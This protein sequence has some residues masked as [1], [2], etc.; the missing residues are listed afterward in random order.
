MDTEKQ[1]RVY[2]C[3]NIHCRANGSERLLR[4]LE[5]AV[6]ELGLDAS[7]EVRVSGCQSRCDFGPNLTVWPGPVRYARLTPEAVRRIAEQHLR[8]GRP[9]EE[10]VWREP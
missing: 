5:Q 10:F 3:G 9:L 6:W 2:V 8:D 4:V 7:V 1:C